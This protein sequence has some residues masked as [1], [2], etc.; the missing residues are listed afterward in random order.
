MKRFPTIAS[1]LAAM[2]LG[3]CTT[4]KVVP[5]IQAVMPSVPPTI[6]VCDPAPAVPVAK[7]Q[8][9]VAEYIVDLWSAGA[10]CRDKLGR[11]KQLLDSE[12]KGS[13]VS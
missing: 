9:T 5:Q 4:T 6:L 13:G 8:K 1:I 11:V 3:A 7:D 12:S 2:A 10:D